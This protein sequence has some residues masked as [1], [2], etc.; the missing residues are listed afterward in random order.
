MIKRDSR[1]P[2]GYQRFLCRIV[3]A[4]KIVLPQ[5]AEPARAGDAASKPPRKLISLDVNP[6]AQGS[7]WAAKRVQKALK[8][9]PASEA[10]S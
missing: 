9:V 8:P 4:V 7:L 10:S 1:Q 6:G 2:N 5:Q 3:E